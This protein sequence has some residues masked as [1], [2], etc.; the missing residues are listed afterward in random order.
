MGKGFKGSAALVVLTF[1]GL[2]VSAQL[3]TAPT[4][5][6]CPEGQMEDSVTRMCWSQTGQGEAYGGPGDGP[7]LPGRLGSCV[8]SL[9]KGGAIYITVPGAVTTW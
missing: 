1:G 5:Y 7:C 8:G 6:A 4:A 3:L 2:L 9:Q